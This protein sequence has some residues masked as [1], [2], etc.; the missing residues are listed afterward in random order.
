MVTHHSWIFLVEVFGY[1]FSEASRVASVVS[2]ELVIPFR[3]RQHQ[4][5]S[6]YDDHMVSHVN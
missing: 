6:V 1:D 3:A 2:V 4:V 5:A